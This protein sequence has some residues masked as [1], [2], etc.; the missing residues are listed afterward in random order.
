MS[1]HVAS[2]LTSSLGFFM[3]AAADRHSEKHSAALLWLFLAL[4]DATVAG[5]VK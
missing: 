2:M 1:A 5:F 4:V 3:L